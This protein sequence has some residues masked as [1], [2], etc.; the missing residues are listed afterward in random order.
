MWCHILHLGEVHYCRWHLNFFL[1][2]K[3]RG[4][5]AGLPSSVQSLS[6]LPLP[7]LSSSG[8]LMG[9]THNPWNLC[10]SFQ[11]VRPSK[12]SCRVDCSIQQQSHIKHQLFIQNKH[13]RWGKSATEKHALLQ[14]AIATFFISSL[15][16]TF[17]ISASTI[18]LLQEINS[19]LIMFFFFSLSTDVKNSKLL[20]LS[21]AP[22]RRWKTI[23]AWSQPL[24]K[25]KTKHTYINIFFY[26][27][28]DCAMLVTVSAST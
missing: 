20:Y 14:A 25:K 2:A 9:L 13:L 8:K 16:Q 27:K 21:I 6:V 19:F 17:I 18:Q 4:L 1:W 15:T 28:M 22:W 26:F 23:K 3:I 24:L 11:K 7:M 10:T 12:S 5:G